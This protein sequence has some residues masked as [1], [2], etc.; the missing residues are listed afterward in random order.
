MTLEWRALAVGVYAVRMQRVCFY[1]GP[2][3][4]SCDGA[5]RLPPSK[6]NR[7]H[8][9]PA[10][11]C[12]TMQLRSVAAIDQTLISEL[13]NG[14]AADATKSSEAGFGSCRL[15]PASLALLTITSVER[16]TSLVPLPPSRRATPVSAQHCAAPISQDSGG[17]GPTN[18][19]ADAMR[20]PACCEAPASA[21]LDSLRA[22]P[23]RLGWYGAHA[24]VRSP[25]TVNGTACSMILP[26][27][28]SCG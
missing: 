4:R 16:V 3:H 1:G 24:S 10:S 14:T 13:L 27:R 21:D 12:G 22:L 5:L 7:D 17:R 18:H 23:R 25:R 15:P 8:R 28:W 20:R 11:F 26:C 2:P 6:P 9:E 19:R